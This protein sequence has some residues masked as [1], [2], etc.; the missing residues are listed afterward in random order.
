[1]SPSVSLKYYHILC[2]PPTWRSPSTTH[3]YQL[4]GF[5]PDGKG[6]VYVSVAH[7]NKRES[8]VQRQNMGGFK[9]T[10]CSVS[11]QIHRFGFFRLYPILVF[12]SHVLW[13]YLQQQAVVSA[14]LL[15]E[16]FCFLD[17][18]GTSFRGQYFYRIWLELW[19]SCWKTFIVGWR[20]DEET[21]GHHDDISLIS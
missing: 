17:T 12:R 6:S 10:S 18:W 2:L 11:R 21:H 8:G 19:L 7:I 5:K 3:H 16:A 4:H 13:P 15:W 9:Q 1:M 20:T 14:L